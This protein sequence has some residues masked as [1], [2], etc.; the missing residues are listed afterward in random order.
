MTILDTILETKQHEVR[1]L[2]L[3]NLPLRTVGERPRLADS[4]RASDTLEVIAEIKRASPSK[5]L[6]HKDLDAVAQATRYVAGG[7]AAISVL[8]DSKYFQ[9]SFTDLEQVAQA[10]P[11]PVLCKDFVID[12]IQIDAAYSY[13]ASIILLIVAALD[14]QDLQDLYRYATSKGLEVLVEVHD[15]DELETALQLGAEL[16]GV[17]NRD[18]RTFTVSLETTE[19]LA[20]RV[21]SLPDVHLISE[22]GIESADDAERLSP[23]GAKGLLVGESLVRSSSVE[24][25]LQSLKVRRKVHDTH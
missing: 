13:G 18:L 17:N 1:E 5:G 25:A 23:C 14:K 15:E 16:I 11:L 9:G 7:A 3:T 8:T 2:Q 20:K 10:V 24:D 21:S 19:R 22:S 4:L 6:I 12:R